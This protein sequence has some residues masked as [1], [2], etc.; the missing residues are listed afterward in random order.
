[1]YSLSVTVVGMFSNPVNSVT[2]KL[3]TSLSMTAMRS[4]SHRSVVTNELMSSMFCS[5]WHTALTSSISPK[6]RSSSLWYMG[7]KSS[8]VPSSRRFIVFMANCPM[9]SKSSIDQ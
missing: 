6:S 4:G 2:A 7:S 9:R 8:L 3:I 5:S 1:M